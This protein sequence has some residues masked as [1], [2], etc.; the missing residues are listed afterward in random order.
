M[1][2][3]QKTKHK[4]PKFPPTVATIFKSLREDLSVEEAQKLRD[5]VLICVDEAREREKKDP[6]TDLESTIELANCCKVLLDRYENFSSKQRALVV[7]AVRYFAGGNDPLND[8]EFASGLWDDKRVM[9]YVLE[10][11]GI[12]DMYLKV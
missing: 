2:F 11:L 5:E 4:L 7:A 12:E 1:F 8:E 6:R 10:Q 9:N 3:F